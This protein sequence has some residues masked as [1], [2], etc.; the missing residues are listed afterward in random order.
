MGRIVK[1]REEI[2]R[3][4]GEHRPELER[5]GV[6]SLAL[7]GSTVRGQAREDSDVDLLV[8]FR[9]PVGLFEFIELKE[10]LERLLGCRVDL[11]T[12][13]SLRVQLR[14][15]VLQEAVYVACREPHVDPTNVRTLAPI[16]QV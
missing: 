9:C 14:K 6:K 16:P 10:Y 15:E 3:V 11:G 1:S 2:L 8:E 7:F 4:L 13:E 5:L 12:S